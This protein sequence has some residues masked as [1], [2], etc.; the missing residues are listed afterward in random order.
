MRPALSLLVITLLSTPAFSAEVPSAT[1]DKLFDSFRDAAGPGCAVAASQQGVTVYERA[2]GMA[3]LETGTSINPHS[4]FHVASISKQFTAAAIMLLERDGKLSIDDDIRKYLPEMP[5]YGS[6]IT[7]RHLMTHTSGL[8]DQWDLMWMSRGRFTENRITEAD[9]MDI[10]PRQKGINFKPGA[11]SSYSNT[12]FTLLAVI[13]KRVSGKSLK[14]FADERIFKP[15]DMRATHFHDDYTMVVRGR[16]SAYARRKDSPA[17]HVAI[18]NFDTYGATSLFTTVGDL[19]KWQDNFRTL[20]VGDAALF[21]RMQT[22]AVLT[23][24]TPV[25]EALGLY[26]AK[27]RGASVVEHGGADAGYRAYTGRFPDQGLAI[28]IACNASTASP[29]VIARAMADAILTDQLTQVEPVSRKERKFS[30]AELASYAG[31]YINPITSAMIELS[32]VDG[33]LVQGEKGGP[34]LGQIGEGRYQ[35]LAATDSFEFVEGKQAGLQRYLPNRAPVFYARH[36]PSTSTP[37]QLAAYTGDYASEELN[38]VRYR[39]SIKD[40]QLVARIGTAEPVVVKELFKDTFTFNGAMIR[41][42]SK[43]GRVE[44]FAVTSGRSRN[45]QFA[46]MQAGAG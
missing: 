35:A 2:F 42:Q 25:G 14:Q 13:V 5:D 46:R 28:A 22:A 7:L 31:F 20:K 40:G 43:A 39:L 18:P 30:P 41:F 11:E 44:G 12:G 38:N 3:N 6:T 32:A 36:Q 8:R 23:S 24:G 16:A 29:Q 19:L 17:W 33:Q 37:A 15:L 34:A 21:Q 9:V 27:Y 26:V 10:V 45:I 4:I 1:L